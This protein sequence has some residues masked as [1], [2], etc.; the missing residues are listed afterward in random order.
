MTEL[1]DGE[2]LE[3]FLAALIAG[4]GA[5][6]TRLTEQA[7]AQGVDILGVY[8][9]L[10]RP[11]LYRVGELWCEHRLS[12]ASEHLA[13]AITE[14]LMNRLYPRVINPRRVGRKA[15]LT[16]VAGE[17]HQVGVKMAADVFERHGWDALFPGVGLSAEDLLAALARQRPDVLGLSYSVCLHR[18]VLK[19]MLAAIRT[20]YPQ[21]PILVGGQGLTQADIDFPGVRCVHSLAELDALIP[22]LIPGEPPGGPG[23]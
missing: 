20:A 19:A 1:S 10:Y 18:D 9:G 17:L 3:Q 7:L 14:G 15:L 2:T 23:A 12:V 5:A 21:L 11:A 16:T 6:C 13:T 4:D 8:E 22:T